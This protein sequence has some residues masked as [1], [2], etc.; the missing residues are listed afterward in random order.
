MADPNSKLAEMFK[1][2][3]KLSI[4][5]EGGFFLDMEA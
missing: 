1:N 5:R 4:M 3:E 2:T